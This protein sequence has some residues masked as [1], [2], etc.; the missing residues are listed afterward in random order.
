MHFIDVGMA[1]LST[2]T[3]VLAAMKA[4]SKDTLGALVACFDAAR[5]NR[6][7]GESEI[8]N[9]SLDDAR[10]ELPG[11]QNAPSNLVTALSK[12][13]DRTGVPKRA[14]ESRVRRIL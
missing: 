10:E 5:R 1:S 4:S 2:S 11:F 7:S 6:M 9:A 12:M 8:D 13:K 14:R 3:R